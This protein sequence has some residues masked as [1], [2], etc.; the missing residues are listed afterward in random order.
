M[1]KHRQNK[2]G[3]SRNDRRNVASHLLCFSTGRLFFGG[4]GSFLGGTEFLKSMSSNVPS[5]KDVSGFWPPFILR[6]T[7]A[8]FS[9]VSICPLA[10]HPRKPPPRNPLTN[11]AK[12][13]PGRRTS[14]MLQFP[15]W[16]SHLS[17][18]SKLVFEKCLAY[19]RCVLPRTSAL[20]NSPAQG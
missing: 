13:P 8:R 4:H 7:P 14:K 9:S 2:R 16:L 19:P 17:C 18:D 5:A 1:A 12:R 11:S 15:L 3:L 6:R 10:L 20:N